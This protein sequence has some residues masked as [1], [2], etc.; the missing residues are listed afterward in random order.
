MQLHQLKPSHKRKRPKRIGRGGKRGTYSGRGV[1]GQRSRAG[2][3]F[4]P[5]IRELMKRYPKKRGYR[6]KPLKLK[7]AIINI[8]ILE[9]KFKSSETVTPKTLLEKKIIRKIKG[10]IPKVKILAKGELKKALTIENCQLSKSTKEKI[11]K[12]GGTI[13]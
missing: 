5:A 2:R 11:E 13:N 4:K 8:G 10:K 1:K 6:F 9:K 3:K 12:A 7:P